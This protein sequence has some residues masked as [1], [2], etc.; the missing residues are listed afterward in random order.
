MHRSAPRSCAL[1][2]AFVWGCSTDPPLEP[3]FQVTPPADTWGETIL[4]V[5]KGPATVDPGSEPKDTDTIAGSDAV[6]VVASE[7]VAPGP[8]G[9]GICAIDESSCSCASDCAIEV[10]GNAACCGEQGE[11]TTTCP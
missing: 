4:S 6:D 3:T 11:N 1:L 5:D 7:E 2:V 8:C 9:D 10:C